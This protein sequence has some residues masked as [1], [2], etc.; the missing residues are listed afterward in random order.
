M[1]RYALQEILSRFATAQNGVERLTQRALA[2]RHGRGGRA[3][4]S[5]GFI[6]DGD[7]ENRN[8]D[9]EHI[10][11]EVI[12]RELGQEQVVL[13]LLISNNSDLLYASRRGSK[14]TR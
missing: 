14:Q 12:L 3:A 7:L 10:E 4:T 9:K 6:G 2:I 5:G 8:E 11:E 13:P 1:Q